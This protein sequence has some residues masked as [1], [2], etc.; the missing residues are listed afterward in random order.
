MLCIFRVSKELSA[1]ISQPEVT[2]TSYRNVGTNKAHCTCTHPKDDRNRVSTRKVYCHVIKP[3]C[4]GIHGY[5][6]SIVRMY[7]VDT[8]YV[9]VCL[10]NDTVRKWEC[11]WVTV[12]AWRWWGAEGS[13]PTLR[14]CLGAGVSGPNN[15]KVHHSL[16]CDR[17]LNRVPYN[18]RSD[19]LRLE[20]ACSMYRVFLYHFP[21]TRQQSPY[22]PPDKS[23]YTIR[24]P[25][26]GNSKETPCS[27]PYV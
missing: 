16:Y 15:M 1:S 3:L 8:G 21:R 7:G 22:M 2:S 11:E 5:W 20:P 19:L 4:L 17:D 25:C 23:W 18:Y 27:T 14:L 12:M 26:S 9:F 6:Y 24:L 10:L 13:W